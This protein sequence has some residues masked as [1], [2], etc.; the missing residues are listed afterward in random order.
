MS[1]DPDI[2]MSEDKYQVISVEKAEPPEGMPEGTWHRY[3]IG[4]GRGKIDGIKPGSL[5]SVTRHAEAMADD[6][7]ERA[8]S[9]GSY[10][11]SRT[12]KR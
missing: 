8:K 4:H 3:V 7:N 2:L 1:T 6:L 12:K 10:Y 9:G 11:A 5:S